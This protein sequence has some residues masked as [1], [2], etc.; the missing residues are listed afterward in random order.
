MDQPIPLRCDDTDL[1]IAKNADRGA[2][3]PYTNRR[4]F[5]HLLFENMTDVDTARARPAIFHGPEKLMRLQREL[6]PQ[7]RLVVDDQHFD[8]QAT[9]LDSRAQSSRT[10]AENE[11]RNVDF[12]R[13][14][15]GFHVI[16]VGQRRTTFAALHDHAFTNER[17]AGLERAPIDQHGA[18]GALAVDAEN[19]LGATIPMMVSEDRN[20]R[21]VQGRTDRFPRPGEQRL[22]VESE[23]NGCGGSRTQD[24][25]VY[26]PQGFGG[27]YGFFGAH[28]A[29]CMQVEETRLGWV[30]ARERP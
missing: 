16:V 15:Q 20:A 23:G 1:A 19:A 24:R 29:T 18:L 12:S 10:P 2:I 3:E 28:G 30:G 11:N 22:A 7:R 14:S 25:M 21:G 13:T 4:Q 5:L 6:P 8:S 9:Q 26:D 17:H 27:E